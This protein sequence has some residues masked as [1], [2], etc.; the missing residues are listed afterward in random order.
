[1]SLITTSNDKRK[2]TLTPVSPASDVLLQAAQ[3]IKQHQLDRAQGLLQ[4]VIRAG[5]DDPIAAR[6][7]AEA[8]FLASYLAPTVA[9]RIAA[10][11]YALKFNPGHG[12]ARQAAMRAREAD[13]AFR[14]LRSPGWTPNVAALLT[15]KAA[16]LP[17]KG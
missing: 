4:T 5:G 17:D 15:M 7:Q 9:A 3:A 6:E 8:W 10:L 11:D 13:A 2:T 16:P 12:L 1:M 14:D